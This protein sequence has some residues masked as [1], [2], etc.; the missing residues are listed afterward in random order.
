M[1]RLPQINDR[2]VSS[3]ILVDGPEEQTAMTGTLTLEHAGA[4]AGVVSGRTCAVVPSA[5]A[6][7]DHL[8][9][10]QMVMISTS[11]TKTI[12]QTCQLAVGRS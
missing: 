7:A 1:I 3:G 8:S 11:T 9:M 12:V 10:S 5:R 4:D 2:I 6:F